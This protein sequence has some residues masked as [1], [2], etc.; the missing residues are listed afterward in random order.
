MPG[1]CRRRAGDRE[2]ALVLDRELLEDGAIHLAGPHHSAQKSPGRGSARRW[3]VERVIVRIRMCCRH[4]P[5]F[6][7]ARPATNRPG[8]RGSS[9]VPV[10]ANAS[11]ARGSARKDGCASARSCCRGVL[12]LGEPA[13]G[14][15][16]A[17]QPLPGLQWIA[18]DRRGPGRRQPAKT[19]SIEVRVEPPSGHDVAV[20]VEIE[21][22]LKSAVFGSCP[23]ATNI[24]ST[25]SDVPTHLAGRAGARPRPISPSNLG[26]SE[27]HANSI[28]SFANARLA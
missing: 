22:T 10:G 7:S 23:I 4:G 16:A 19:P 6:L 26:T 28:L 21:L 17:M 27:F 25:S 24:P 14:S 2:L 3:P 5:S 8:P 1:C 12:A 20:R 13:L 15:I 11:R 18:G 9:S